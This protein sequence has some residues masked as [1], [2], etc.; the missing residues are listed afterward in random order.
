MVDISVI[1]PTYKPQEYLWECL[2]S[3]TEQSLPRNR[4]EIIVV[5]NGEGK[6]YKTDIE[7]YIKKRKAP[8]IC[9]IHTEEK[10]VSNARNIGLLHSKGKYICFVDDDDSITT[11]Y[12]ESML[13]L[14]KENFIICSDVQLINYNTGEQLPSY[15]HKAFIT[16]STKSKLNS[17]EYRKFLSSSCCKLIPKKIIGDNRFDGNISI[18]E[19]SLFMFAIS[20]KIQGIRLSASDQYYK[21]RARQ[22]SASRTPLALSLKIGIVSKL[23]RAYTMIWLKNWQK[24]S[25]PLFV[26]RIVATL[27]KLF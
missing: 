13:S 5:L 27:M 8:N 1:V 4:Y 7:E 17:F 22:G 9:L 3:L 23:I 10:G 20:Y 25:F 14:A 2:D 12:L 6:H 24:Y 26:S 16:V 11:G 15:I 18:G 21:I 19:D